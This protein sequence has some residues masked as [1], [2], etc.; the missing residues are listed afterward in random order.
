[1]LLYHPTDFIG[2]VRPVFTGRTLIARLKTS[3]FHIYQNVLVTTL[4]A[5][6]NVGAQHGS[7]VSPNTATPENIGTCNSCCQGPVGP[8]G[9]PGIPGVGIPGSHGTNGLP[10][11]VG[12]KGEPGLSIKGEA[13]NRGEAGI[14]GSR[15]EQGDSGE[16]GD[17]GDVGPRGFPGKM[18]PEGQEGLAGVKGMQGSDG[19]KGLSGEKG[20]PGVPGSKGEQGRNAVTRRSAFT[21]VMTSAQ[22]GSEEVLIFHRVI[23]NIG[24]DFDLNTSKFT[25]R[26]PGV[27]VFMFNLNTE[28][29]SRD[30][31][32]HLMKN[33]EKTIGA[34]RDKDDNKDGGISGSAVLSL[35]IGD[36]VWIQLYEG[37]V[38]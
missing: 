11:A 7:C 19:I 13:G 29:N 17:R 21:A 24:T 30:T 22:G 2:E 23:T 15:G 16:K 27:Y 10:G 38:H 34:A 26:I 18:G 9:N 31:Q 36:N 20:E 28:D 5:I 12:S 1:M 35:Q 3:P 4:P 25:C 32:V 14:D 33:D 37:E 6:N 8:Q